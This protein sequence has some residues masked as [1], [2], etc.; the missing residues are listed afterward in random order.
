MARAQQ[1]WKAHGKDFLAGK[2]V[3]NPELTNVFYSS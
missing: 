3:P 2:E 1:W